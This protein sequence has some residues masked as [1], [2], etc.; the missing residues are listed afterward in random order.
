[1]KHM[2]ASLQ[3]VLRKELLDGL[4]DRRSIFAALLPLVIVP[5][6][7][8]FG[9]NRAADE[10]SNSTGSARSLRIPVVGGE[11]A[12]EFIEWMEQQSGVG[13]RPGPDQPRMRVSDG[14]MDFV[15]V[16]P[17]DFGDRFGRAEPAT[18]QI[19]VDS[20]DGRAARTASRVRNLVRLYGQRVTRQRLA[21]LGVSPDVLRPVL[22]ETVEI[23]T[24]P[25]RADPLFFSF[26]PF[27]MLMSTFVGGLQIA[28]DSTSGSANADRLNRCSSTRCRCSP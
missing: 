1:M 24:E 22:V 14:Q 18:V 3:V 11:R 27:F 23:E 10:I 8:F 25:E 20:S 21:D 12:P 5:C 19:I 15:L 17:P 7:L 2:L 4:R 9:L 6:L 28:I 13:L 16:I 26:L